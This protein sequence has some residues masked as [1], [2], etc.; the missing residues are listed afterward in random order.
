MDDR[1]DGHRPIGGNRRRVQGG[2]PVVDLPPVDVGDRASREIGQEL[3]LEIVPVDPE[4]TR[5][6][7]PLVAFEHGPGDRFEQRL[8]G[9]RRRGLV[10]PD[11]GQHLRG[12]RPRFLHVQGPGIADDFP[13]A[14]STVLAVDEELLASR[15]QHPDAEPP[16]LAVANVVVGLAGIERADAGVGKVGPR[17][18]FLP[19]A[20]AAEGTECCRFS[21]QAAEC[22]R[23]ND[24]KSNT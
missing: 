23:K 9:S 5:L 11:R 18:R 6:P 16:E 20:V 13:D 15:G 1:E 17:H 24:A 7:D 22:G 8:L 12:A 10:A 3:V 21:S 2:E 19:V 4:R 14:F